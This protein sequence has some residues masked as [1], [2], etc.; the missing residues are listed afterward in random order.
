MKL[1]SGQIQV[2]HFRAFQN[3]FPPNIFGLQLVESVDL[4]PLDT[5]ANCKVKFEKA[6]HFLITISNQSYLKNKVCQYVCM[7]VYAPTSP[8]FSSGPSL[9]FVYKSLC[10]A[11]FDRQGKSLYLFKYSVHMQRLLLQFS[12]CSYCRQLIKQSAFGL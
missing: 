12:Y 1:A 8:A 9:V 11:V 2:L 7:C 5:R 10:S 4:E 3:C 6:L